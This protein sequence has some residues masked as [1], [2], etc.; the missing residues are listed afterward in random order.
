MST[1]Q[2]L[3]VEH[4]ERAEGPRVTPEWVAQH[5][6]DPAVVLLQVDEEAA[7]HHLSHPPGSGFIDW[8]DCLRG[9]L[10]PGQAGRAAFEELMSDRGILPEHDV[11]LF[12]DTDNQYASGMLWLMRLH[13]HRQL[14]LMDGGRAAWSS[15]GLPMTDVETQRPRTDY[16]AGAPVPSVRISRDELLAE[17][18]GHVPRSVLLDCR[19]EREHAGHATRG[20]RGH[21]APDI[22]G[23]VPGAQ[24]L[25][26]S[27]LLAEDGSLLD[28]ERIEGV[29]ASAGLSRDQI[30]TAYCHQS[31]RSALAWFVLHEVLGY[32]Q[33]R[34]YDG[35]WQEYS[36]L[37]GVQVSRHDEQHASGA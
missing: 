3:A 24:N 34:V 35:G 22:G 18:S 19:S 33:V 23:H 30:I 1:A 25:P 29:L 15:R 20:P 11:V 2:A 21:M 37:I 13:G 16:R 17:V 4:G 36:N 10:R 27:R 28:V 32:P 8:Q 14:R 5:L 9:L 12:G 6:D 7:D 26:V 31:D